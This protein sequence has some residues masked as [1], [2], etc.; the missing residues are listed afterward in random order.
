MRAFFE[1]K[2]HMRPR[3]AKIFGAKVRVVGGGNREKVEK[4][5]LFWA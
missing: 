2:R 4:F 3:D 1:L 5:L